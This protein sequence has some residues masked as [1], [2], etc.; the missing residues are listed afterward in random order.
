[1]YVC[2][3]I[4]RQRETVVS[5]LNVRQTKTKIDISREKMRKIGWTDIGLI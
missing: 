2:I 4:K 1:M 5:I 3:I